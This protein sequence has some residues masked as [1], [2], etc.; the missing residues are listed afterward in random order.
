MGGSAARCTLLFERRAIAV[1]GQ[2]DVTGAT[3]ILRVSLNEAWGIMER[4]VKPGRQRTAP[5]RVRRIGVDEQAA[6]NMCH[7]CR[8]RSVGLPSRED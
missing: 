7:I 5:K 3:K 2:C 1:L 4:A 6:A 8:S